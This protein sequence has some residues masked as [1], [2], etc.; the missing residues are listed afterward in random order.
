MRLVAIAINISHEFKRAH[1][2]A[3]AMHATEYM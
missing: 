1:L 3:A 2:R